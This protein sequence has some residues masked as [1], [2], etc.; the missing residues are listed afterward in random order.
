MQ[1]VLLTDA[2]KA[3]RPDIIKLLLT[4]GAKVDPSILAQV[5]L[6]SENE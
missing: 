5:I 1:K 2:I 3:K 6:E 4:M